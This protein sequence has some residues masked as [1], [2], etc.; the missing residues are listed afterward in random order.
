MGSICLG[1]LR[2]ACRVLAAFLNGKLSREQENLEDILT[3]NVFGLLSYCQPADGTLPFLQRATTI[4]GIAPLYGVHDVASLE[5]EFWPQWKAPDCAPCE[6][7]VVLRLKE[8]SGK[9]WL[10]AIEAKFHSG[11]SSGPSVGEGSPP[12]DQLAK[13]CDNLARIAD[14]ERAQPLLVYLTAGV[15]YPI[16]DV[17]AS[18]AELRSKRAGPAAEIVWLS[19]RHLK[20][21]IRH[22]P[23]RPLRDL[24][25]LLER[26]DLHMFEGFE[27]VKSLVISWQFK[28][29]PVSFGWP[30]GPINEVGWEFKPGA[31]DAG[32]GYR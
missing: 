10:I 26:L 12:A 9:Q 6:P 4:D 29:T 15:G 14:N 8:T 32:K 20:A 27:P 17:Q 24:S 13:E 16:D 1:S 18:L 22:S 7:D 28:S 31:R 5:F 30:A 2:E 23:Q 19:W 11:K 21:V 3:S 25:L